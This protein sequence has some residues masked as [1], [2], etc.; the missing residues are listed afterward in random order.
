MTDTTTSPKKGK[1]LMPLLFT[2][3]AVNLLIAGM[4]VGWS[5][6]DGRKDRT[7][8]PI[9]GVLGEPFARALPD[10]ARQ[11]IRSDIERERSRISES[12]AALRERFQ[13]FLAA[14]RSDPFVPEDVVQLLEEQRQVGITRQEFGEELL[15]RRLNEMSLEER[16]AYAD[17]LEQLLKNLRRR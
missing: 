1:W 4:V 3:L 11:A 15:L 13:A 2:S 12:R 16:S 17:R 9:R 8:G 7:Q 6:S 10:S 14:L 5:F